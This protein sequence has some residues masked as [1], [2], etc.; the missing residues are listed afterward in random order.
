MVGVKVRVC[1]ASR[2]AEEVTR[3]AV[4][5]DMY[6]CQ[7]AMS[8]WVDV[9]LRP[10]VDR[11][12]DSED[13][14]VIAENMNR[15]LRYLRRLRRTVKRQDTCPDLQMCLET[16]PS[17]CPSFKD[18]PRI[19]FPATMVAATLLLLCALKGRSPE[20]RESDAE[21]VGD[22]DGDADADADADAIP[23]PCPNPCPVPCL[24]FRIR[25]PPFAGLADLARLKHV[26]V[27]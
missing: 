5:D 19:G 24:T 13:E 7:G 2:G 12:N 11:D 15:A 3:E 21:E 4:L 10:L 27:T 18:G 17:L 22:G 9:I 20:S 8:H 23:I 16:E 26:N 1:V 25:D 6:G 14:D